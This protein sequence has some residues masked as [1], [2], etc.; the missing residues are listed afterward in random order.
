[1]S[2]E[3]QLHVVL[4]FGPLGQAAARALLAR[5]HRVR[6][7]TRGGAGPLP[8]G[9]EAARA[10]AYDPAQVA[11]ASAGATAVYQCAQPHYHE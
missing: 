7:V 5:G 2:T 8:A 4:G 6:V 3:K 10:G 11:A 1:M 9:A